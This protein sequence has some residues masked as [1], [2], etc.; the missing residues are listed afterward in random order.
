MV[1]PPALKEK[2]AL[3]KRRGGQNRPTSKPTPLEAMNAGRGFC[4]S[5]YIYRGIRDVTPDRVVWEGPQLFR[6]KTFF[7]CLGFGR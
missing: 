1:D 4:G 7:I 5:P 3:H 2:L 6:T